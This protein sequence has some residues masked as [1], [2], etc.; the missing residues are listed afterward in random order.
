MPEKQKTKSVFSGSEGILDNIN[1]A[2]FIY[3]LQGHFLLINDESCRRLGYKKEEFL[4]L[5][6]HKIDS[7]K[8]AKLV[9]A[10]VKELKEKGSVVFE[11]EHVA[12]SGKIIPVEISSKV[13]DY[14]GTPAILS[15]A[16][17]IT[18]RKKAEE[19][20]KIQQEE[21]QI[22]FDLIPAWIFY[23]DKENRFVRVNQSFAEVMKMSVKSL[24][25]KSMFDLYPKE[26]AESYWQDDK[27]VIN[28]GKAKRNIIEKMESP[29]GTLWVRTD[30]I[31][32]RNKQGKIIGI[33]GFT[34]DI[35]SQIN[36][37]KKLTDASETLKE[38]EQKF[39]RL[40]EGLGSNFFIY[41]HNTKGVFKYLSPSVTEMLGY[42]IEEFTAHYSRYLTSNPI[43]KKVEEF[44]AKSIRGIKQDPYLVEIYHKDKSK[45]MLEV[46]EV[47][48]KDKKGKVVSIE[49]IA[50]DITKQKNIENNIKEKFE[51]LEKINRLMVGRELK[52]IELKEKIQELEKSLIK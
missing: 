39:R 29:N 49:G 51:E 19:K 45:K 26:Q 6:P 13:I 3:N 21:N 32:Y 5:D 2:I 16:R 35:T 31:P 15:I 52:M 44:T 7:P 17:D 50:H 48:V 30:K 37:E 40:I 23:K 42:S 18:E 33:I 4:K 10:R 34:V 25:G 20:I 8:F 14:Q 9:S 36:D 43:N 11:S 46:T 28:S 12:K 47:P 24:E 38:S 1:D 22:I 41:S 27:K